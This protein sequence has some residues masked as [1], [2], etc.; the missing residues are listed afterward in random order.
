MSTTIVPFDFDGQSVRVVERD[1]EPWFVLA[2][3]CKI[4]GLTNPSMAAESIDADALSSTEVI[5]SLGRSQSARITD[6]SG[7][8]ALAFKSRKDEAK[9]F[10][11]WV[12]KE[13]LPTI[14][15]TGSYGQP[16][17]LSADEI[18]HQA[19]QITAKR[20][21]ALQAELE[22]V[23][24]DAEAWTGLSKA[25]GDFTVRDAAKIVARAGC[26]TGPKKLHDVIEHQWEWIYRRGAKN[27][28]VVA[29][30]PINSGFMC[31]RITSGYFDQVS[32]ERKNGSPEPRITVK[33][34]GE[35]ARRLGGNPKHAMDAAME[36][37]SIQEG[38][39][40]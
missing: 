38:K 19:L 35:I 32:G 1:G 6:E 34:V 33:G 17:E 30:E 31:A 10:T 11:K 39:A 23:K 29:Q 4:L 9:A 7:L 16:K 12:T 36:A 2:D 3:I 13:V 28:R 20:V 14:R 24:P 26:V 40:A 18:V 21:E 25:V 37:I 15:K 22:A 8:Y 5:D 27:K